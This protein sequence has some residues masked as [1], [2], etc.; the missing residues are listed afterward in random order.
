LCTATSKWDAEKAQANS[1]KHGVSFEEAAEAFT[2]PY[3]LDFADVTHPD[4]LV[5]LAMSPRERILYLVTVE[6]GL[7]T[8]IISARRVTT[9]EQRIYEAEP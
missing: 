9:H 2:D 6:R 7:R 4:R 1:A 8:R 3:S 5:T